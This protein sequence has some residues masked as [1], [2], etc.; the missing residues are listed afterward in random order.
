MLDERAI[1]GFRD[2]QRGFRLAP[3]LAFAKFPQLATDDGNQALQVAFH[4]SI[5]GTRV[6]RARGEVFFHGAGN[7]DEW[8]IQA[9][10]TK[11]RECFRSAEAGHAVVTNDEIPWGA[12]ECRC[13]RVRGLY[14]L[15]RERESRAPELVCQQLGV[16]LRIFDQQ[17]AER[18]AHRSLDV[19]K[20]R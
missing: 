3:P 5:A 14:A 16:S 15:E 4:E 6:E 12:A 9:A 8:N 7:E 2:A 13:Q 18:V 19:T 1:G 17:Q 10:G 20:F 11:Q